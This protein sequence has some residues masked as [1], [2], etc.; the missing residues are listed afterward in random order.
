MQTSSSD[1]KL[2][3]TNICNANVHYIYANYICELHDANY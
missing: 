2:E 3:D 1:Q